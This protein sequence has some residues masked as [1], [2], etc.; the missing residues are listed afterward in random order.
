MTS[1]RSKRT[2]RAEAGPDGLPRPVRGS[3]SPSPVGAS[4][5]GHN[6]LSRSPWGRSPLGRSPVSRSPLSRSPLS[7]LLQAFDPDSDDRPAIALQV[8]VP[9]NDVEQP[10]HHH[11]K[12]QLVLAQHGAVSCHVP[13][14]LWLVPPQ[15][16]VW[17]P[18]G[19]PHS[20][21]AT[22]NARLSLLFIEPGAVAMP[23]RC[24]TLAISPLVREMIG[25]LANQGPDYPRDSATARLVA[26]LLEQLS[27]DPVERLHL[28]V[29]DHPRLR[30]L[31]ETLAADPSDR[32]TLTTWAGRLAMSD[33]TLAR[34]IQRETGL[35]FGRWRRQLQLMVA[36]QQL[37]VGTPVQQVAGNLGYDSVTAF[38]TMFRQVFG[39]SPGQYFAAL[40]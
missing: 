34:L 1:N 6:S 12:G 19:L 32:T 39:R 31:A 23:A 15:H 3:R 11:R 4:P 10:V 36:L 17:I 25:H 37:A 7:R 33:R 21:R 35:T 27:V 24:C 26:V 22:D 9:L 38:I 20:N 2:G 29:P 18:G 13:G 28:P 14:A 8:S 30:L 16:A 5:L 40:R